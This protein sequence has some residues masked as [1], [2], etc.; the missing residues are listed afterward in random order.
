[1]EENINAK[2]ICQCYLVPSG[3]GRYRVACA[4]CLNRPLIGAYTKLKGTLEL[5]AGDGSCQQLTQEE[6]GSQVERR[7]TKGAVV[8]R[9]GWAGALLEKSS[10]W[11]VL[12]PE[13]G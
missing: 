11:R 7:K 6:D 3:V 10:H 2:Q 5:L 4:T 9:F 8:S 13:E 1:M 12:G